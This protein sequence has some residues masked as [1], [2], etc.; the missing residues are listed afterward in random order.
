[1]PATPKTILEWGVVPSEQIDEWNLGAND[2]DMEKKEQE[3]EIVE[4]AGDNDD[5]PLTRADIDLRNF[6]KEL[7]EKKGATKAVRRVS[8]DRLPFHICTRA[9][10]L[11]SA[12][13]TRRGSRRL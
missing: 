9:L 13:S 10:T 5:I 4:T 11:S 12:M 1:M 3:V 7:L 6:I 2:N 8:L